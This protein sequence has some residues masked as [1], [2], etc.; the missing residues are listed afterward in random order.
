[1]TLPAPPAPIAYAVHPGGD[2]PTGKNQQT[3]AAWLTANGINPNL[4][5]AS[6]PITVLPIPYE[7]TDNGPWMVQVIVFHQFY[8]RDDGTKDHN[9]I[10]RQ[11]VTFQRTVPLRALF[12]TAP[13][14]EAVPEPEEDQAEEAGAR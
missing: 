9:L 10:T 2:I 6:H 14:D 11:P 8:M 13:A 12:P 3:L 7:A 4:V 1:M 5:A